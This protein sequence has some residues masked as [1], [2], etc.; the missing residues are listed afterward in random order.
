MEPAQRND[1]WDEPA[2]RFRTTGSHD[3]AVAEASDRLIDEV[4]KLGGRNIVLEEARSRCHRGHGW[5]I[6]APQIPDM[7][8]QAGAGRPK[9]VSHSDHQNQN[10][11]VASGLPSR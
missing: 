11:H 1:R 9:R 4:L 3:L 10:N 5:L 8:F 6:P 2:L 7:G